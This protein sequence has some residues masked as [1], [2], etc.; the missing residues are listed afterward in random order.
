VREYRNRLLEERDRHR[1]S[2]PRF[3]SGLFAW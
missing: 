1:A 2:S 3:S